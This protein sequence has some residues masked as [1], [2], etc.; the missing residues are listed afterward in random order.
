MEEDVQEVTLLIEGQLFTIDKSLLCEHSEYFRAMFSGNYKENQLREIAIEVV[1]ANSMQLIIDWMRHSYIDL[2]DPS[3]LSDLA[4]SANYLQIN[5]LIK[6]IETT[7]DYQLSDSTWMSTLIVAEA[8][9]YIQ[10][11][12]RS[13]MHGLLSFKKMKPIYVPALDRLHWYLSHPWL[14]TEDEISVFRFGC[15]WIKTTNS[16]PESFLIILGCLDMSNL[17]NVDFEE[18]LSLMQ[19][20]KECLAYRI[21]QFLLEVSIS[22]SDIIVEAIRLHR[23]E[24]CEK[25]SQE[26]YD[27]VIE[28]VRGSHRR[29]M[30]VVPCVPMINKI[31]WKC[32][33]EEASEKLC[34]PNT[35]QYIYKFIENVGFEQW[36]EVTDKS[37]WGWSVCAWGRTKVCVVGGEYG[38]GSG[39]FMKEIAIWD[40]IRQ[41][42][43]RHSVNLPPRRHAGLACVNDELYIVGGV[44]TFRVI[45][46]SA[47]VYNLAEKSFRKIANIPDNMQNPAICGYRGKIYVA[48]HKNIYRYNGEGENDKWELVLNTELRAHSLVGHRNYIYVSQNYF[49]QL[50]RFKPDKDAALESVTSFNNPVSAVCSNGRQIIAFTHT[51]P[52]TES[53]AVE[54]FEDEKKSLIWTEEKCALKI[55]DGA[56]GE[57]WIYC[58][59]PE[60]ER[61]SDQWVFSF[62][63]LTKVKRGEASEK[64]KR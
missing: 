55:Y 38:R 27:E 2:S 60:N 39:H 15:E 21:I 63:L 10:L 19:N 24:L 54:T 41:E 14:D 20:Y 8:A 30:P 33:D 42:W 12:Y 51:N 9:S 17:S 37:L 6:Q 7:L 57:N 4:S 28:I 49:N 35:P 48:S 61:Q 46:S 29:G 56:G 43:I 45:L 5:E 62:E 59:D 53:I 58:Y 34:P 64:R 1:D 32:S 25:H 31:D 13:A 47:I 18:M 44:G 40:V 11:E 3:C 16:P 22:L 52:A 36:L 23:D 50:Y 26:V